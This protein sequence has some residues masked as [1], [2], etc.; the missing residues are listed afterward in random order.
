MDIKAFLLFVQICDQ[1]MHA[2]LLSLAQRHMLVVP[3]L[4]NA[5]WISLGAHLPAKNATSL[6]ELVFL[7][8]VHWDLIRNTL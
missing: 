1:I 2:W 3:K 5:N 6:A 7:H 8:F 4:N